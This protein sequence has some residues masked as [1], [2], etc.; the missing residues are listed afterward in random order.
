MIDINLIL[1]E[2]FI[3]LALMFLLIMG[4]FKKNSSSLIYNLSIFSLIIL[5]ALV[6]N[7]I[8]INETFLFNKSYKI[9]GLS[10]FMKILT[11]ISGIFVMLTSSKYLKLNKIF[12]IE[13]PVLIL[14]SILG[15]VVMIS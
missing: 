15:M 3:S 2:I 6:I 13:Y 9:D 5:L 12:K 11:M 8:S 4:V 1:P 7:L 10:T 14:C